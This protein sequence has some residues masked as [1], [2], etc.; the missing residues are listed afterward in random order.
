MR[1]TALALLMIAAGSTAN[2]SGIGAQV[3][4][5][6]DAGSGTMRMGSEAS[7]GII[8]LAP[9]LHLNFPAFLIAAEGD[10]A[11]HT[12]HGWQTIGRLQAAARRRFLGLFEAQL[13]MHGAWSRTRWGRSGAGW[14]GEGRIQ[15]GDQLRGF[16][17]GG[18]AGRSFR[19]GSQPLTRMEARGW[20]RLG[21]MD[22][23]FLLQR[24]GLAVPGDPGDDPDP[25][26][27][28]LAEAEGRRTGQD[29]YTDAEATIGWARGNLALEAGAGR[30]FGQAVRFTS[31]HVRALYQ[32]TSRLALVASSGQYPVDIISGLPSGGFTTLSMRFN[33]R[34]EP[35]A[36]RPPDRDRSRARNQPFSTLSNSDGT[37]QLILR[38]PGAGTVELMGDFTNWIPVLL[39]PDDQDLWRL[40]M[41]IPAGVHEV[42]LRVDGGPWIVPAGLARMDDGLGGS[43]GVFV[44]E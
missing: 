38:V 26:D 1:M 30:R 35:P 32:V 31:W 39:V 42:N 15:I 8:R 40:T 44:V 33:L 36:I 11:G 24:T 34:T 20:G 27:T 41:R 2:P 17:I 14:L 3:E 6:I 28:L 9:A 29:H 16:A 23:A 21:V 4:G 13:G 7:Y 19:S 43:V 12:E 37:A 22:L 10:Y 25:Q 18:G 5:F